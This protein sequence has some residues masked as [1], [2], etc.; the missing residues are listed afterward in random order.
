MPPRHPFKQTPRDTRCDPVIEWYLNTYGLDSG[1]ECRDTFQGHDAAD[2]IRLSLRRAGNHYGVSVAAWVTNQDGESCW[3]DCQ[4]PASPHITHFKVHSK[5]HGRAHVADQGN[6][7]G[8]IGNWR[9]NPYLRGQAR[10]EQRR[11]R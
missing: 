3:E 11:G 2:D 7:P 9:Y 10:H 4:D 1:T 6:Q 8:G 5:E